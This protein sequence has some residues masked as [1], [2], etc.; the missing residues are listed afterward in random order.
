MPQRLFVKKVE[1]CSDCP[2]CGMDRN[3]TR[4]LCSHPGKKGES[5]LAWDDCDGPIPTPEGCPLPRV[6]EAMA[7]EEEALG[8]EAAMAV[9]AV[10]EGAKPL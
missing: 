3:C 7:A 5:F 1:S 10:R 4:F 8:L 6:P 9:C 2:C